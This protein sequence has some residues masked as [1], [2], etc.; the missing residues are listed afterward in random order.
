MQDKDGRKTCNYPVIKHVVTLICNYMTSQRHCILLM[1]CVVIGV[2]SSAGLSGQNLTLK[3]ATNKNKTRKSTY[4]VIP[5]PLEI[6][7][8]CL[9]FKLTD[10][11]VCMVFRVWNI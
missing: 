8:Y 11:Y 2:G 3:I 7:C 6:F 10:F 9:D 1:I 5:Y 4:I